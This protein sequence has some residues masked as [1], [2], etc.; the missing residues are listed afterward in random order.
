MMLYIEYVV[1]IYLAR[2]IMV[3]IDSYCCAIYWFLLSYVV[4][5]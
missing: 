2:P 3:A 5:N 4:L 1:A